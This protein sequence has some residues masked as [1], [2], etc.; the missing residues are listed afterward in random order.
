MIRFKID[1][2]ASLKEAGYNQTLLQG[3]LLPKSTIQALKDGGNITLE[4]LNKVCILTGLQPGDLLE[5]VEVTT[6]KEKFLNK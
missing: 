6:E 4:S 5:Y 3:G 1:I 2:L